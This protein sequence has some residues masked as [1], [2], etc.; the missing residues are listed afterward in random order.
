MA[1]WLRIH[2]PTQGTQVQALV[3]EDPTCCGTTKP[4]HHQLLSLRSR[5]REP[6]L[7]LDAATEAHAPRAPAPQREA[8]AMRSPR[9]ATE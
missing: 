4:M 2:L 8:T 9:T 6:L 3:Q 5:A 7:C 1:Q